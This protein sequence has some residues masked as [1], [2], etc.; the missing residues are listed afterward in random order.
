MKMTKTETTVKCCSTQ[1]KDK[2]KGN[3]KYNSSNVDDDNS[4]RMKV[5]LADW[6]KGE[7]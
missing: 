7:N 3:D 5:K 1:N 4:V 2:D 6:S